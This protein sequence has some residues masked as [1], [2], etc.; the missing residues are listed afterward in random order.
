MKPSGIT[1]AARAAIASCCLGRNKPS[2]SG[3]M[4][5]DSAKSSPPSVI[6]TTR[7]SA[8]AISGMR[9]NAA[10]VSIITVNC[11]M[12]TGM[13]RSASSSLTTSATSR[14]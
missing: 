8:P 12:P 14:T 5:T 4:P 1:P 13:P 6:A 7:R 9:K 2:A 3:S 10:A 11:V